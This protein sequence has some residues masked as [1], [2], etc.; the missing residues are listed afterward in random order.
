MKRIVTIQDISCLGKCSLT[1]ALPIISAMGIETSVIP[2]AV[3]SAHTIFEGNTFKDLTDQIV[4]I[5][6]HWK[7]K[8][9]DFDAVYTGYLASKEQI[10]IVSGFIDKFKTNNNF[11]FV[12]PVMADQGKLYPS[13]SGDFP[14]HMRKLCSKADVISP[15]LTE[16]CIMTGTPMKDK[17]DKSYIDEITIKLLDIGCRSII[18]TGVELNGE[19][20][21]YNYDGSNEN[22]YTHEKF[23]QTFYGTGDVFASACVGALTKG[24]KLSKAVET[25]GNFTFESIKA[26]IND[27]GWRDYGINFESALGQL[28][29]SINE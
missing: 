25:A 16:A 15:N 6:N 11:I 12:D 28:I 21:I 3:L 14:E 23:K 5:A 13:F 26:S 1:V 29:N 18:L 24:Y 22:Y 4:P 27:P 19:Y 7:K 17:Y 8:G 10:S 2:T 9:F 20:G